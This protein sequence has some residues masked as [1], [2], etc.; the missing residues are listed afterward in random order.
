MM[1]KRM[2]QIRMNKWKKKCHVERKTNFQSNQ[3]KF[4]HITA[5]LISELD[6]DENEANEDNEKKDDPSQE[7]KS[8]DI[9]ISVSF[10]FI[11]DGFQ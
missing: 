8:N 9:R 11:Q 7:N 2:I 1:N 10:N 3:N 4:N 5:K 6:F